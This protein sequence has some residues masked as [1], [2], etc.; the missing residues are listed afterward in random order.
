MF[1]KQSLLVFCH[2]VQCAV[3]VVVWHLNDLLNPLKRME[4]WRKQIRFLF[5]LK[6]TKSN[7]FVK[8]E[9]ET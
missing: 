9:P 5:N 8:I 7:K 2:F 6:D 4:N 3:C 1:W